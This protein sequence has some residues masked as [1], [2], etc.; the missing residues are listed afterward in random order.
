MNKP[1]PDDA[2]DFVSEHI[3][4]KVN[5]HNSRGILSLNKKK[6]MEEQKYLFH[7]W[8]IICIFGLKQSIITNYGNEQ[9]Y[10]TKILTAK[11]TEPS[12]KN[13]R[14]TRKYKYVQHLN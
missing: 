10:P 13:P 2:Q 3:H 5:G 14:L 6:D 12:N 7:K 4:T 9:K 1:A 8:I 11:D